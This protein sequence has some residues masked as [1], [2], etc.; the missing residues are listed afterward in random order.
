MLYLSPDDSTLCRDILHPSG[1]QAAVSSSL[2]SDLDK[3]TSWS[4]TWNMFFNPD[5]SH[6]LY[7]RTVWQ[8][9]ERTPHLYTLLY[10]ETSHRKGNS[11]NFVCVAPYPYRHTTPCGHKHLISLLDI[12]VVSMDSCDR[13]LYSSNT[14][15][16]KH[17]YKIFLLSVTSSHCKV[18]SYNL[19]L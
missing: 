13:G 9:S 10:N 7:E 16:K 14:T 11:V 12:A 4:N 17:V 8:T 1:R 5:K 3:F 18:V 19:N 2:S 6:T 15:I